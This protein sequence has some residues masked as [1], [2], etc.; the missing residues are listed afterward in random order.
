MD[1]LGLDKLIDG[2]LEAL[3]AHVK[4]NLLRRPFLRSITLPGADLVHL[5]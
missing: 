3:Y 2:F 5:S 4:K 1:I